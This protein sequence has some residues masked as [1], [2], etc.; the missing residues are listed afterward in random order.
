MSQLARH[1]N[2]KKIEIHLALVKKEG[3]YLK[4]I[5]TEVVIHDLKA[6]RVRRAFWPLLKLLWTLRPHAVLST[7]GHLNIALTMIQ[8]FL[9]PGTKILIRESNTVSEALRETHT[10]LC[11]GFLYKLFY[12]HANRIICQSVYMQKDL[13]QHFRVPSHLITQIYNPVDIEYL[14]KRAHEEENPF[15]SHERRL[16][17]VGVGRLEKQKGFRRLIEMMPYVLARQPHA[18]LWILGEGRLH[19][20]L[21]KLAAQKNLSEHVH[22]PGFQE[23]PWVWLKHADLFVLSSEYEGLPNALLEAIALECPVA[24]VQNPGGTEEILRFCHLSNRYA[25]KLEWNDAWLD[26]APCARARQAL[27][28][29][30][31]LSHIIHQYAQIL[32][33]C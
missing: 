7:L 17:I 6:G 18:H 12:R 32:E 30:F 5:P 10:P 27:E 21:E 19:Y 1:L 16:N 13:E 15:V 14:Q 29:H 11:W 28:K 33:H 4:D 22:L 23:N 26:R 8:P 31:A 20:D 9:P 24:A 2:R 25:P 3:P